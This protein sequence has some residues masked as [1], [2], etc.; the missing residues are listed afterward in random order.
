M[1]DIVTEALQR[2][3]DTP[4]PPG[5]IFGRHPHDQ[6]PESGSWFL[7]NWSPHSRAIILLCHQ[8][9][10]PTQKRIGCNDC[11]EL[12]KRFPPD[13]LGCTRKPDALAVREPQPPHAQLFAQQPVFLEQVLDHRL[14]PAVGPTCHKLDQK[15]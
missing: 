7:F 5:C 13:S 1:P 11:I 14:L 9:A 6:T 4:I 15:M 8:Y 2:S 3:D 10:I 12:K